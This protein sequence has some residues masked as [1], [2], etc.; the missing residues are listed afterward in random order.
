MFCGCL[1]LAG[2][3]A[4]YDMTA[5]WFLHNLGHRQ[6]RQGT[7]FDRNKVRQWDP[8]NAGWVKL[9]AVWGEMHSCSVKQLGHAAG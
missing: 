1:M 5:I 2:V 3:S 4:A 7:S 6:T 8:L 9:G